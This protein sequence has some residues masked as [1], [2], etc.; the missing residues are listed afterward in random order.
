MTAVRPSK[1]LLW[2]DA[3]RIL[4]AFLVIVNH[5][6][7]YLFKA[8]TP[9]SAEWWLSILWYYLS[10]IAVPVF[11]MVSGAALLPK[12]D[13]YK[14]VLRR[15]LRVLIALVL[16][17]YLYYLYDAW[18]YWGLW[19]RMAELGT[20]LH[21]VWTQQITDGFWYLTF[22][23]GLMAMLPLLQRLAGAMRGRDLRYLMGACV[24]LSGV[25]PLA[26]H[27]WPQLALPSYFQTPLFGMYIGLFFA[28]HWVRQ[29]FV[30]TRGRM[31][32]AGAL[33]AV[34]LAACVALTY[35][36]FGRVAPGEPYWFMD[37][38]LAPALPVALMSVAAMALFK[39][40]RLPQTGRCATV[41]VSVAGCTFGIYL[42]QDLL[43]AQSKT[44]LYAPLCSAMPTMAAMLLWE[45]AVFAAAL[46]VVWVLRRIPGVKRIL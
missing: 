17:S 26:A 42:L 11:V 19:P 6:N 4:A 40:I 24:V 2:M 9:Q 33:L 18:V 14:T 1:R 15:A 35:V 20:F 29:R 12:Q 23:L 44:R 7:S 28:G 37:D 36:E 25:C 41:V 43:I 13:S 5:T 10:K 34:S 22:Y 32:A 8:T 38:R 21:L 3:L 31:L 27:Y 16:F 46:A 39:G 45:L 30:P